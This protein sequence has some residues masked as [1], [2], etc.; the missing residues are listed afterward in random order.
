MA[1]IEKDLKNLPLASNPSSEDIRS[2]HSS[3][4]SKLNNGHNPT[5]RLKKRPPYNYLTLS[6]ILVISLATITL[7]P[8]TL[9]SKEY[10]IVSSP[11]VTNSATDIKVGAEVMEPSLSK[12]ALPPQYYFSERNYFIDSLTENTSPPSKRGYTFSSINPTDLESKIQLLKN[13]FDIKAEPVKDEFNSITVGDSQGPT[14]YLY[15]QPNAL[16]S[17]SYYNQSLDPWQTCYSQPR[18]EPAQTDQ[19][20]SPLPQPTEPCNPTVKLPSNDQAYKTAKELLTP[21]SA[22]PLRFQLYRDQYQIQVNAYPVLD[23]SLTPSISYSLSIT[24]KGVLSASGLLINKPSEIEYKIITPKEAIDR[25]NDSRFSA[26]PY[27]EPGEN[28]I[29]TISSNDPFVTPSLPSSDSSLIPYP[30]ANHEITKYAL[31]FTTIYHMEK[32]LLVPAYLLSSSSSSFIVIAVDQSYLDTTP[33]FTF[34]PTIKSQANTSSN[35]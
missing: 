24:E 35:N 21:L 25:A 10:D 18:P 12:S 28:S 5:V 23:Q 1:N 27:Y 19:P 9:P 8:L 16:A 6:T 17:W 33:N 15:A 22:T 2:L 32:I 13:I 30:V 31:T 3:F 26:S 20:L 34:Y 4:L 29:N 14:L 7:S 11:A